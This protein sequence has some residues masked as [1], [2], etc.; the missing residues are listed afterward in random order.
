ML[1]DNG[2]QPRPHD[3]AVLTHNGNDKSTGCRV[4][5]YVDDLIASGD[6]LD[7]YLWD[8]LREHYKFKDPEPCN[9]VLG[10]QL[11]R[12]IETNSGNNETNGPPR[13]QKDET[14][15]GTLHCCK[16]SMAAYAVTIQ[17]TSKEEFGHTLPTVLTSPYRKTSDYA[18]ER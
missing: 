11:E 13:P 12:W 15:A 9:A 4:A 2:W 10:M 7:K 17:E 16:I 5:C 1:K 14:E 3:N 18:K 8:P 6:D